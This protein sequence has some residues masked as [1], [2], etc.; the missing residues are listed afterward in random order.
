MKKF[1]M[2][3]L[4]HVDSGKTTLS[5]SMLYCAGEI[6]KQGRVDHKNSFLDNREIER[7]RGITI[8][9]KQAV[10]KMGETQ[11]TL[12]DTPG[13]VDF[14][15]EMERTLNILDYAVLVIS[16]TDG[17]QSHTETLW[18]LL[19]DYKIPV[20][21]FINKMDIS[22]YSK[23]VLMENLKKN[24][25]DG[26]IDFSEEFDEN[27]FEELAMC[28]ESILNLVLDGKEVSDDIIK[29][30]IKRR[31]VFP[32]FFGS[33]L[34]NEGTK[35]LLDGLC[36][37]FGEIEYPESFGARV[38][39]ISSDEQGKRLTHM[40]ITGGILKVRDEISKDGDLPEKINGIR[41]YSGEKFLVYDKVYPGTVCA[42]TGLEKTN[43][44]DGLGFEKNLHEALLEPVLNYTVELLEGE[45]VHK[46]LS[47]LKK[48]EEEEP[49]LR[50]T[51][52]ER[53]SE[54]N[55]SLMGEVQLEVLKR[56]IFEKY[57][58]SVSFGQGSISYKETIKTTAEGVGH[59]EPLRH[60]AEVHLLLEP[61]ELGS[62]VKFS[63][64][65]SEDELDKNW[66]R[67]ILTHLAEKTH[68]GV[69]TGSP[70]TDMKITLVSGR[71]HKKHTEGG[72]FRQATY[73]AVRH[74]L[75]RAESVLLEPWYKFKIE[76]PTENIGRVMSD[77]QNM[78]GEINSPENDGEMSRLE[79][80][81]PVSKM[82]GYHTEITAFTRGRGR[83]LCMFDS[84]KP[85]TDAQLIIDKIG[86]NPEADTENTPDS[87]FCSHG[88]GFNV[89]WNEVEDYMHIESFIKEK[90]EVIS[91]RHVNN[92]INS[93][94]S[95]TELM[96]I[97]EKTYGPVKRNVHTTMEARKT[98]DE[99]KKAIV[100]KP[101]EKGEN[102]LLIDGY[103]IIFAWD[104]LKE[105]AKESLDLA[106]NS[107]I[108]IICN[109]QGFSNCKVIL[110]FDAYKV[111]GNKGEVERVHNIDVVYTK[112]A[113]T[114]DMYIEKV[115]HELGKK[116]RVRVATSDNLEQLIILGSGAV[117]V[118]ADEFLKEVEEN[119][120]RIK[121]FLKKLEKTIDK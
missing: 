74:G 46:A 11:L 8:F 54:I 99:P 89:K 118:S 37:F 51:W 33:A 57:G 50:V 48:L 100:K 23:N 24:L 109:Y 108:N 73:R 13:H 17:V 41:I 49:Q 58:L 120:K 97:F 79:G 12:V 1:V 121:E 112:E 27:L 92:Y 93:I 42:V 94:A 90:E 26:C 75:M 63:S 81:A 71:A 104:N 67:L 98:S 106:R 56:I 114:A 18:K 110:V 64:K 107:L 72:D 105:Q 28:D 95:D 15:A 86:Y 43:A 10:L 69:L 55:V 34:K 39:K 31:K 30:A 45:D 115:T 62:G 65:C 84:Y 14:S 3:I 76:V 9:S 101:R 96:R 40:K 68:I 22:A 5:E 53:F 59:F 111:K 32:C 102:Y 38:F 83:I 119:E 78:G 66:Q 44:G 20:F 82:R 29:R 25:C 21:I 87:V 36:R 103:N 35:E 6:R 7:E 4:A 77:V 113:E 80:T 16:G 116:H 91:E 2:G 117:R 88:A 61:G 52:N 85:C 70:I 60:Y 47:N 19:E